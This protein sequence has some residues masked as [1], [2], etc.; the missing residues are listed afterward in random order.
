MHIYIKFIFIGAAA[1][2][3]PDGAIQIIRPEHNVWISLLTFAVPL[4][5]MFVWYK[6]HKL[7]SFY[8]YPKAFPLLMLLGIWLL[9]PL[10]IA[11]PGQFNGGG[12]LNVENIGTF[13]TMWAIFPISTFIMSTYS[14]SLGGIALITILLVITARVASSKHKASNK[15]L[16]TDSAKS[17]APVS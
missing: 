5:V 14:G 13:F 10:G 16:N 3:L 11:V 12:F 7:T 1:Y 8:N 17:A 4:T 6:L 2:W 15:A 9:G